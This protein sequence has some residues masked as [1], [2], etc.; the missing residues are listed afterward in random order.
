MRNANKRAWIHDWFYILSPATI[1]VLDPCSVEAQSYERSETKIVQAIRGNDTVCIINS[2][3][4]HTHTNTLA[5]N[6]VFH[7]LSSSIIVVLDSSLP[8]SAEKLYS[9]SEAQLYVHV[10]KNQYRCAYTFHAETNNKKCSKS[11]FLRTFSSNDCRLRF[12]LVCFSLDT[13]F[14][15][16]NVNNVHPWLYVGDI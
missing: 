10:G 3:Q 2:T 15:K 4:I 8:S 13:F 16:W 12:A 9:E 14:W 11:F 6:F 1:V 7:S 5:F